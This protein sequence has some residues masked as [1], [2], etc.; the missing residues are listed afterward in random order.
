MKVQA[1]SQ[2]WRLQDSLGR[3]MQ[4]LREARGKPPRVSLGEGVG[5]NT[6]MDFL[7]LLLVQMQ[8]PGLLNHQLLLLKLVL[9]QLHQSC[10]HP[11]LWI[12]PVQGR[13]QLHRCFPVQEGMVYKVYQMS[14]S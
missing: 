3:A 7:V 2:R 10:L 14:E 9:M 13:L 6:G 5:R 4:V 11:V 12:W 1:G 8:R